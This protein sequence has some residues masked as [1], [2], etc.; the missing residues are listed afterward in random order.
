M[1]DSDPKAIAAKLTKAQRD[2]LAIMYE[3]S[4][5]TRWWADGANANWRQGGRVGG[6]SAIR[7]V[8]Y[9]C[10][11]RL[12]LKTPRYGITDLGRLVAQEIAAQEGRDD[13]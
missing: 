9:E 4:K 11:E 2:A 8:H 6:A 13:G 12:P 3:C 1:T 7:L 10:A 5:T